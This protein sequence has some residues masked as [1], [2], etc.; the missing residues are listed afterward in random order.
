[1]RAP[2]LAILDLSRN[3]LDEGARTFVDETTSAFTG[4]SPGASMGAPYMYGRRFG[5]G[6]EGDWERE[7]T[8]MLRQ[9]ARTL[10]LLGGSCLGICLTVS[11]AWSQIVTN[12]ADNARTGWYPDQASLTPLLVSSPSFGKRF[13]T[14]LIGSVYA[15]PLIANNT[16]FVV[17]EQ[18]WATR[19]DP[20]TGLVQ[21]RRQLSTPWNPNDLG[22]GDLTPWIGTTGTPA[23][24]VSS[25]TAYFFSKTYASGTSGLAAWDAHALDIITGQERPGFPVRI[26][27]TAS[28]NPSQLFNPTQQMQRTGVL[29][30]DGVFYGGFGAHCDISPWQGWVVGVSVSGQ[31]KVMWDARSGTDPSGAGIWQSGGG[32]VS[33]GSGY[34]VFAT[35]NGGSPGSRIPGNNPPADLAD[36]VVRLQVQIDGTLQATDFFA[37]Y[38]A[39]SNL[40]PNDIDLGSG[41]PVALPSAFFGTSTFPR[42]IA[43]IGK[44]GYLYVMNRDSFGGCQEGPGRRDA[45]INRIGLLGGVWS[46]PAVWPGDGGYIYFPTASPGNTPSEPG[47]P[48]FMMK[49]GIDGGGSPTFT[50]AGSSADTFGFGSGAPVVTSNGTTSGS[51]LVWTIFDQD[52][53]GVNAELRAYDAVP[54]GGA[55]VLRWSAPIGTT[56]KF[57]SPG[58]AYG[59]VYVGNRDGLVSSFGPPPIQLTVDKNSATGSVSLRWS[60]GNAPYTLT[61]AQDADFKLNPT[62]LVDHQAV[63][64]F[65]D[66]TLNN[67]TTYYYIVR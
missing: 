36:C 58:I 22:C 18:N 53:T 38:D 1:M 29:L 31:I 15:Q 65:E 25:N 20:E 33:D 67:G 32:L 48:F 11:T 37:P 24:D 66:P 52:P 42:L 27:G 23:I 26:Q 55:P 10:R 12:A 40:D 43:M 3:H 6:S 54:Q 9:S 21:W 46:R 17:T 2:I 8:M 61:Q 60:G 28:N 49:Y 39:A 34:I 51:A 4:N 45:V 44:Q 19:I 7:L 63:T 13:E 16:L 41:T 30:M 59:R 47:G 14:S 35:G 50:V 62:T 5:T 64:S 56:S 57:A